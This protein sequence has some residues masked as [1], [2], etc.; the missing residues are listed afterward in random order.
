MSWFFEKLKIVVIVNI[1]WVRSLFRVFVCVVGV[2]KV[3]W[4][5]DVIV[6][7]TRK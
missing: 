2:I 4:S 5:L 7:K 6:L 3:F 1:F